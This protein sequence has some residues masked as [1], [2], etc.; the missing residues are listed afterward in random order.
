[1]WG[2]MAV[3]AAAAAPISTATFNQSAC[4]RTHQVLLMA[5]GHVLFTRHLLGVV[6]VVYHQRSLFRAHPLAS[7][8]V[9]RF[10]TIF[11]T[12]FDG[13]SEAFIHVK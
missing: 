12:H 8:T 10:I 7:S 11:F 9:S 6:A 2:K 4:T 1:M 5:D 13:P 3:C